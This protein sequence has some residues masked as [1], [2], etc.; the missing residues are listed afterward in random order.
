MY[1]LNPLSCRH[2]QCGITKAAYLRVL[3]SLLQVS[4]FSH[5]D[6]RL[7]KQIGELLIDCY[8]AIHVQSCSSK[9]LFDEKLSILQLNLLLKCSLHINQLGNLDFDGAKLPDPTDLLKLCL[10]DTYPLSLRTFCL[11][12][13]NTALSDIRDDVITDVVL[14]SLCCETDP[15][16]L[17]QVSLFSSPAE[18]HSSV[19]IFVVL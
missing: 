9:Q 4:M 14:G 13:V 10:K 12:F 11:E 8:Q 19:C 7:L 17:I 15:D 3:L 2:N 16:Y 1:S 5:Q 18:L 6:E